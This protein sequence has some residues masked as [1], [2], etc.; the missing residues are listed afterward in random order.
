VDA[1]GNAYVTGFTQSLDFPTTPG[2]FQTKYGGSGDAFVTK[3]N[4]AGSGLIYSSY[5]GGP[6]YEDQLGFPGAI[7]VDASGN[8]YVTGVTSGGAFPTKNAWQPASGGGTDVFVTKLNA[9]GSGLVYSSY[10]G[11]TG[12]DRGY[13]IA[14]DVAGNAYVTGETS[15]ANFPTQ[16]PLQATK[17]SSIY[18]AFVAKIA[19]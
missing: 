1:D 2:A 10:L 13:G 4:A 17:A 12:A 15:S 18:D 5:L 9:D 6:G 3:L 16:N 11:G 8:A 19:G 14:V 7:A